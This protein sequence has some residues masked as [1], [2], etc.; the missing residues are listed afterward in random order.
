MTPYI[1]TTDLSKI[2]KTGDTPALDALNLSVKKGEVYGF[3]G[4]NGAGKSTTIRLLLNF[5]QPSSGRARIMGQD[6]VSEG[7]AIKRLVGYLAGDVALWPK[8]TGNEVFAYLGKLQSQVNHDYLAELIKRFEAEP[9]KRIDQLSKGN[10]QKIGIIQAL[11][12]QPDVLILDEPTSGLDPLM[13]EVFYEEIRRAA[14]RGAAVFVSSHNLTEAQ[15]M[16]DRVGI[17]KHGRLIR[18]YSIKD[19]TNLGSITF[20]VVLTH[21]RDAE[22][23]KANRA[24]KLLSHESQT[25]VVQ[26][27]KSIA[28]AL[29]ALSTCTIETIS[30][31]QLNLEDEFLEYYGDG[32]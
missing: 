21:P 4:A 23:L 9:D 27:K 20:R 3:L 28:E 29:A 19:D 14:D 32:A 24:I 7:V 16:C 31:E 26:P 8:V 18:E 30:T 15:R 25:I 10:R 22:K 6:V 2:F 17:I 5:I 11:M 13:Q 12:H 1:E